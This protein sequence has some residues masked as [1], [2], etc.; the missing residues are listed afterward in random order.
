MPVCCLLVSEDDSHK[1][2]Q[3]HRQR[4]VT[5]GRGPETKIK[6]KKCSRE[7]VEL[8]A[9]CSRGSIS[10]KQRRSRVLQTQHQH[11]IQTIT[12]YQAIHLHQKRHCHLNQINQ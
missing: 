9:D 5:L 2:I 10:V 3:L 12:E 4:S 7:Q 8:R 1:P 11:P 6:D